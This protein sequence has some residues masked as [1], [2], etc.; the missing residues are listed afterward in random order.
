LI[1]TAL[2]STVSA[3]KNQFVE[4]TEEEVDTGNL[5]REVIEGMTGIEPMLDYTLDEC[6]LASIGIPVL[7]GLLNKNFSSK[8][9]KLNMQASDL[10]EA[11]TIGDMVEII[12]AAKG[13]ADD[14][15]V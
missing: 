11:K 9:R 1:F 4:E 15:G 14:K 6:G 8:V 12:D 3:I 5:L 13:L 7:V 10:V 2:V